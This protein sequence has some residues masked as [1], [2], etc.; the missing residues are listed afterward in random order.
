MRCAAAGILIIVIPAN[1]ILHEPARAVQISSDHTATLDFFDQTPTVPNAVDGRATID[2]D[3]VCA[4][5]DLV[6]LK[7]AVR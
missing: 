3:C 1:Q 4:I 5:Q 7:V 6:R 2:R